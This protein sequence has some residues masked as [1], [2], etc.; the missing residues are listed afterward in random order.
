[1]MKKLKLLLIATIIISSATHCSAESDNVEIQ[2]WFQ[3]TAN[4][5]AKRFGVGKGE[6]GYP[7]RKHSS[8]KTGNCASGLCQKKFHNFIAGPCKKDTQCRSGICEGAFCAKCRNL[9][10]KCKKDKECCEGGCFKSRCAKTSLGKN[11]G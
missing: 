9:G 11:A 5:T 3:K 10:S 7:C 6:V 1:M 2:G 4:K 8:C